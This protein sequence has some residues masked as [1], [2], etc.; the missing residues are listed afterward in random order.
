LPRGAILRDCGPHR[1][2]RDQGSGTVMILEEWAMAEQHPVCSV[3]GEGI[4]IGARVG[5][6]WDSRSG[7]SVHPAFRIA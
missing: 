7:G 6:A 5:L 4:A 2:A 3:S 1:H